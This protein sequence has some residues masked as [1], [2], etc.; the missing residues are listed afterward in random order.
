MHTV[1]LDNDPDPSLA[2]MQS[3]FLQRPDALSAS[4]ILDPKF[5]FTVMV[6]SDSLTP[7]EEDVPNALDHHTNPLL[8][9]DTPGASITF[10]LSPMRP[11]QR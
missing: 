11:S 4:N 1:G 6:N 9:Q 2:A 7:F 3:L 5:S 10:S 8:P